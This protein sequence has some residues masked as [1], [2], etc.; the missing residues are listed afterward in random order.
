MALTALPLELFALICGH[1][2]RVDWFALRI[3]CRAAFSNTFEVFAK[4]YYTS[5]R[6]LLTTES[7]RRLERIAADDT[8]RPFVQEL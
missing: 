1:R 3:P 5:L 7:L 8:L 2:E 6:L 4:R